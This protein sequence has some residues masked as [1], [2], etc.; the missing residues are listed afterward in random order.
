MSE[1]YKR[2]QAD[3][4]AKTISKQDIVI[5]T[6][7]IPGRPA[8]VLVS[9]DMVKTMRPGSVINDLAVEAGGNCP[10]SEPGEVVVKHGV[11]IIGYTNV[12]SRV[13]EDASLLYA[14]NLLSFLTPLIDEE[15]GSLNIDWEDEIIQGAALTR[16]GAI[17]HPL[18]S[19]GEA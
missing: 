17:I 11:T 6:A 19:K 2:K 18:L 15:N 14:R 3:L 7:L 13:A 4:I 5:T 8:P 16:D 1:D 9:E 10:L 12:P